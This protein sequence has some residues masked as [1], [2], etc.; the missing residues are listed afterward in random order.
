M[1]HT[2]DTPKFVPL[3]GTTIYP[4]M[5]E[6]AMRKGQEVTVPDG[7]ELVMTTYISHGSYHGEVRLPAGTRVR[8]TYAGNVYWPAE[9][10]VLS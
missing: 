6:M 9:L 10:T 7:Y 3:P 4:M 2:G 5:V 1:K 8:L